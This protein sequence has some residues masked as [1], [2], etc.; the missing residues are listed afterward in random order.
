MGIAGLQLR[1]FV[2][3][4]VVVRD[5]AQ[6]A[7]IGTDDARQAEHANQS[8]GDKN[9]QILDRNGDLAKLSGF[10]AGHKKDVKAFTQYAYPNERNLAFPYE[11]LG[12][13]PGAG[14]VMLGLGKSES[15][16]RFRSAP[17]LAQPQAWRAE[18]GR[19]KIQMCRNSF[20]LL[21]LVLQRSLL[22]AS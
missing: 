14:T 8:A 9:V 6:H 12:N 15:R 10:V 17:K 18:A 7:G 22:M 2:A 1:L 16:G 21:H 20:R 3:Q 4:L 11:C 19:P 13:L 5:L